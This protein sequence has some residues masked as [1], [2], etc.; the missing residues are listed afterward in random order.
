M[1]SEVH[2]GELALH[3]EEVVGGL[4]SGQGLQRTGPGN[5]ALIAASWVW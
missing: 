2:G 4:G 5:V 1:A 3:V